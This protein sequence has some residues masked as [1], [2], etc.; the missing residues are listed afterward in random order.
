MAK[1]PWSIKIKMFMKA[2]GLE[3]KRMAKEFIVMRTESYSKEIL[4]TEENK[5]WVQLFF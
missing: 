3:E 4:L 5:E 1:E 2:F